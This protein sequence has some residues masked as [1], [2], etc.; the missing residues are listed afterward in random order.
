MA[1][2][3]GEAAS[4]APV[5]R[6][7]DYRGAIPS[8]TRETWLVPSES[9]FDALRSSALGHV[10][11][12][13]GH[14][15]RFG[16]DYEAEAFIPNDLPERVDLPGAVWMT[17]SEAM[18]ELG[19]LDAA[20]SLIPNPQLIAR[21]AT[22]TEAVGTS[23]L[24]GTYAELSEVFAAEVLPRA[25]QDADVP[26]NVREVMN[27]TRAADAAY[28]WIAD[29]PITLSL[30]CALQA[31][32]VRG[33]S[34]DGPE[35]GALRTTQVFIGAKNRRVS[36]ARFIP[37]PP[38]DPLRSLCERWVDWLTADEAVANIQLI[39]RVAMA[40]YQFETLHPFTDGNGRVGRLITVLQ[41]LREKALRAPVL[42][43]SP[44]LEEHADEYR[45]HLL[46]VST[47]GDWAPWIDFFARAVRDESRASHD[48]IMRL[49][50]FREEIAAVV[51]T[52]L[53][54]ARLAIEIADDLIAYP[55]LSV[56]DAQRRYG[57]S[58]QANRNAIG[59][60]VDLG[61]LEPYGSARY[62]RLYWNRQVLQV[63]ER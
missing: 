53:P 11:P 9:K 39:A 37:P 6:H 16:E 21:I 44:W 33:T 57:R 50:A 1:N 20:A 51:R 13:T 30:L 15:A 14:D 55:V 24:E 63:I 38:G 27:Y 22:R 29:R 40:H 60:L 46:A 3:T 4:R 43:V 12:I 32:I 19:R 8:F 7:L 45:D 62:D 52:A 2:T 41:I 26:P 28:A 47:T 59:A 25:E 49:L 36:E 42:A 23:A 54:R 58:N 48:R 56:A 10:L 34:S 18:T 31:E 5:L 61:V 17:V 35:S